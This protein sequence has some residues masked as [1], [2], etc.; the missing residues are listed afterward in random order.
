MCV[1][2]CASIYVYMPMERW[3]VSD[4]KKPPCRNISLIRQPMHRHREI[5]RMGAHQPQTLQSPD[6][7]GPMDIA[8][9]QHRSQSDRIHR[10]ESKWGRQNSKS[11]ALMKAKK[12]KERELTSGGCSKGSSYVTNMKM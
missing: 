7:V 11:M 5:R 2:V 3:R 9:Y 8:A 1:C 12:D 6:L 10:S 4:K